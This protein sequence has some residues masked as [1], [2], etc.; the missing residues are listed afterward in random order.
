MTETAPS[1]RP[2]LTDVPSATT[3][4]GRATEGLAFVWRFWAVVVLF[5]AIVLAR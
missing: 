5:G 4:D 3:E 1:R 2:R